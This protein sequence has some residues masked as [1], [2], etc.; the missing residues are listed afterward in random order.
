MGG[1]VQARVRLKEVWSGRRCRYC[2]RAMI[3]YYMGF[4][5]GVFCY[6]LSRGLFTS[7]FVGCLAGGGLY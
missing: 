1:G 6:L 4:M 3:V 7:W 5:V 2:R